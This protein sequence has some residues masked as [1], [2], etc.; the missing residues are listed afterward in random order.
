MRE[1]GGGDEAWEELA[2]SDD[3]EVQTT[4]DDE[5]SLSVTTSTCAT[6]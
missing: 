1:R 2:D 5:R 4:A 6:H 3:N